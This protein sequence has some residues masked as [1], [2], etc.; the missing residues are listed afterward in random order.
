MSDS[1]PES[2]TLLSKAKPESAFARTVVAMAP[3]DRIERA[4]RAAGRKGL[5]DY[6][7]QAFFIITAFFAGLS[8]S[9]AYVYYVGLEGVVNKLAALGLLVAGSL[10]WSRLNNAAKERTK[11]INRDLPEVLS[12]L[13]VGIRSGLPLPSAMSKVVQKMPDHPI[14]F[15]LQTVLSNINAGSTEAEAISTLGEQTASDSLKTLIG[16]MVNSIKSGAELAHTLEI[17]AESLQK[18]KRMAANEWANKIEVKL[19]LPLVMCIFPAF[20]ITILGP[21]GINIYRSFVS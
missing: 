19:T 18:A 10:P 12:M 13:I 4:M 17:Q 11:I 2:G 8:G 3:K 20:F 9:A 1:K 21:A 14:A 7:S 15:E 5:V 16:A 6:E